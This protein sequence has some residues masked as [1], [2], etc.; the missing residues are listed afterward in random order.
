MTHV[1]H[2]ARIFFLCP[3]LVSLLKKIIFIIYHIKLK[4]YH[5]I[6]YY[7]IMSY[8]YALGTV[9]LEVMWPNSEG[10]G[11]KIGLDQLGSHP[12]CL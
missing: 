4:I 9:M 6:I 5:L 3:M 10:A 12:I 11:T 7:T 8:S 1:L 2:A